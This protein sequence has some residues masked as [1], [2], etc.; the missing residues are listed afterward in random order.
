MPMR[1]PRLS[2]LWY[3]LVSGAGWVAAPPVSAVPPPATRH[4]PRQPPNSP[5]SLR[6]ACPKPSPDTRPE[7]FAQLAFICYSFPAILTSMLL[8]LCANVPDRPQTLFEHQNSF[9]ILPFSFCWRIGFTV[10]SAVPLLCSI[11]SGEK[12]PRQ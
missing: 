4:P 6:S 12:L 2:Q 5:A 11:I 7:K 3:N 9:L 1:P 10:S 8:F